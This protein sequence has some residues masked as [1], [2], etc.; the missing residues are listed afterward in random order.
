MAMPAYPP[1]PRGPEQSW[2]DYQKDLLRYRAE[3][4]RLAQSSLGGAGFG[5]A[6]AI[7]LMVLVVVMGATWL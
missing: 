3:M 1:P 4:E 6:I 5:L 2:E 7:A